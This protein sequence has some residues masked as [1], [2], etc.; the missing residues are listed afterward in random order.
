M[1]GQHSGL[2][3][4]TV[5]RFSPPVLQLDDHG[6]PT[7]RMRGAGKARVQH[8]TAASAPCSLISAWMAFFTFHCE[9]PFL[10]S[11][12]PWPGVRSEHGKRYSRLHLLSS[13]DDEISPCA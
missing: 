1:P 2:S 4:E 3:R 10:D 11:Y 13:H 8:R 12:A 5:E 6:H 7:E 9:E